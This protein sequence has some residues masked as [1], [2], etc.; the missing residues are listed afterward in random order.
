M[1]RRRIGACVDSSRGVDGEVMLSSMGG[2]RKGW[3]ERSAAC[4]DRPGASTGA[5]WTAGQSCC[6]IGRI[7]HLRASCGDQPVM[8]ESMQRSVFFWILAGGLAAATVDIAAASLINWRNPAFIL[9]FIAS[10]LIGARVVHLGFAG[11]VLGLILQ[12][13][14]G[15]IIASIFFLAALLVGRARVLSGGRWIAAALGYGV[16][17]FVVMNY[18]VMPLS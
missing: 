17:I 13:L 15:V 14:M 11:V 5:R 12:W 3:R 8:R 7:D 10:G 16:V 2:Q 1:T 18:I 4:R 9:Q 6:Y